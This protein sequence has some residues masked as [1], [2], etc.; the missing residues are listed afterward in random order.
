MKEYRVLV[1]TP[2]GHILDQHTLTCAD[3][4]EARATA[5]LFADTNP[6]EIWIGPDRV[7]RLEPKQ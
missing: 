3:D 2:G 7:V 4:D 5:V 1:L 6:V